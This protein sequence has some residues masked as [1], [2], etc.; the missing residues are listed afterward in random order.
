[1]PSVERSF[2]KLKLINLCQ[3]RY[4][5]IYDGVD[6]DDQF[7]FGFGLSEMT[8]NNHSNVILNNWNVRNCFN[9]LSSLSI[10]FCYQSIIIVIDCIPTAI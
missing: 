4:Y 7:G 10:L 2:S 8:Y 6:I 5:Y 1:M 9:C 3:L